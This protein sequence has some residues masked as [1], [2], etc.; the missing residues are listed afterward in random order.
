[1]GSRAGG[2]RAGGPGA[3]G[4]IDATRLLLTPICHVA[5]A[6]VPGDVVRVRDGAV[7]IY[8]LPEDY[9]AADEAS[10]RRML[11]EAVPEA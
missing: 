4:P 1:M 9:E 7:T 10:L 6:G 3:G 11:D 5:P 8:L 2:S